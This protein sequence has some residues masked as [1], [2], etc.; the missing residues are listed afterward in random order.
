M[1]S[2]NQSAC[3]IDL[4]GA[5]ESSDSSPTPLISFLPMAVDEMIVPLKRFSIGPNDL[6]DTIENQAKL[7]GDPFEIVNVSAP[8]ESN[9][10]VVPTANLIDVDAYG[11]RVSLDSEHVLNKAT[12]TANSVTSNSSF[13]D[14][15][16]I[17]SMNCGFLQSDSSGEAT[18][19]NRNRLSSDPTTS[20]VKTGRKHG[21]GKRCASLDRICLKNQLRIS[22]TNSPVSSPNWSKLNNMLD[23]LENSSIQKTVNSIDLNLTSESIFDDLRSTN[24]EWIESDNEDS[25]F[26]RMTIPFLKNIQTNASTEDIPVP[27]TTIDKLSKFRKSVVD[28]TENVAAPTV[29]T[30]EKVVEPIEKTVHQL[31]DITSLIETLR[32]A[33][34]NC[35]DERKKDEAS[36]LLDNLNV[37]F[38]EANLNTSTT[39]DKTARRSIVRQRTFCVDDKEDSDRTI[40]PSTSISKELSSSLP[41]TST[42]Q[43][44]KSTTGISTPSPRRCSRSISYDG[45]PVSV[46]SAIQ[47]QTNSRRS[48]VCTTPT[49]LVKPTSISNPSS[50]QT[51]TSFSR[52]SLQSTPKEL[53]PLIRPVERKTVMKA[54]TAFTSSGATRPLKLR[55]GE[56]TKPTGPLKA[57]IP[58]QRST[59]QTDRSDESSKSKRTIKTSTPLA[60]NN[61]AKSGKPAAYS[62]PVLNSGKP[63]S[64]SHFT[65]NKS[66][67]S[68]TPSTP[69]GKPLVRQP[70]SERRKRSVTFTEESD[71]L[72]QSMV[73]GSSEA[74]YTRLPPLQRR[75]LSRSYGTINKENSIAQKK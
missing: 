6:F 69:A 34:K 22:L 64:L 16:S 70:S 55:V 71:K 49:R 25:D 12:C 39:S 13:V 29:S 42:V 57:V 19:S 31:D 38:T 14:S 2:P 20:K 67:L 59:A 65:Y 9:N 63:T 10:V 17:D 51:R 62:T 50:A 35:A 52:R 68:Y 46:V 33:V 36:A 3:L 66:R 75:R 21:S 23:S 45:R 53:K 43:P 40:S 61:I 54:A 73:V 7:F 58:F 72:S 41:E 56:Q 30:E 44:R 74:T 8:R 28:V 48:S 47:S 37:C 1:S 24:P 5:P 27:S 60:S 26:E 15:N 11:N 4:S 18:N 32:N